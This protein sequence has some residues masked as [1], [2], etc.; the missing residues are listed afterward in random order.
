MKAVMY[1]QCNPGPYN[2]TL[3]EGRGIVCRTALHCRVEWF[4]HLRVGEGTP[5][6]HPFIEFYR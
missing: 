5:F 1:G 2:L 6:A 4:A 3:L